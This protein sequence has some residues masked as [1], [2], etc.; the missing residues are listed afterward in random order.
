MNLS[1]FQF[2]STN[3]RFYLTGRGIDGKI[4]V[5]IH[6]A[7]GRTFEVQNFYCLFTGRMLFTWQLQYEQATN[8]YYQQYRCNNVDE[9][10]DSN[11]NADGIA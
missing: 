11:R 3:T 5:T 8:R 4:K 1:A 9:R 2:F 10:A 6:Q 7:G